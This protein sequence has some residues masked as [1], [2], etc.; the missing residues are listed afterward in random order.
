V[1]RRVH[2]IARSS[3]SADKDRLREE[4]EHFVE[5][6]E[7]LDDDALDQL[8]IALMVRSYPTKEGQDS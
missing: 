1:K 3:V 5:E 4:V 2:L 7:G 8:L 6:Y